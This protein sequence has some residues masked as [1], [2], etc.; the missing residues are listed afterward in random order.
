MKGKKGEREDKKKGEKVIGK[1]RRKSFFNQVGDDASNKLLGI[2]YQ[3]PL[4]PLK[5][6]LFCIRRRI[7]KSGGRKMRAGL[8]FYP[9]DY[10]NRDDPQWRT[11]GEGWLKGQNL[12]L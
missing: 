1:K 10:N 7:I 5:L 8:F 9:I 2:L 4:E 6:F 11:K 12:L 3:F